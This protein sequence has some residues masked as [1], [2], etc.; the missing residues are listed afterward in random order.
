[1]TSRFH[2]VRESEVVVL[3][4]TIANSVDMRDARGIGFEQ[5][6]VN[7]SLAMLLKGENVGKQ[8]NIHKH[9]TME[10]EG[11][12]RIITDG[13]LSRTTTGMHGS[14]ERRLDDVVCFMDGLGILGRN[15]GAN[16]LTDRL[17]GAFNH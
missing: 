7:K 10:G 1:M 13:T 17:M 16:N 9:V 8:Q 3:V 14:S 6:L 2:L 4:D 15:S 12:G 11:T 5:M